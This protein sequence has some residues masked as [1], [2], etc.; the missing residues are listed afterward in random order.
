MLGSHCLL[1][2]EAL[3]V[4]IAT[5]LGTLWLFT[6][7]AS[8]ALGASRGGRGLGAGTQLVCHRALALGTPLRVVVLTLVAVSALLA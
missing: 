8:L 3:L 1:G 5:L 6:S 7:P 4:P 2:T